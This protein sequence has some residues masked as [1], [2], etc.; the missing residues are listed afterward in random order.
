MA[1]VGHGGEH[2][3]DV[4][5]L[6]DGG[7]NVDVRVMHGGPHRMGAH[8][9]DGVTIISGT[10]LTEAVKESIRSVLISAGVEEDVTFIDASEE[11]QVRV[12]RK[13]VETTQ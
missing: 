12:I 4:T 9:P 13:R 8:H 11:R 3:I 1:F 10:E 6:D 2:D 5:M 7:E